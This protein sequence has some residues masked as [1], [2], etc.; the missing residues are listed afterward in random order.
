MK[1]LILAMVLFL[2]AS[3]LGFA[4]SVH[5][6]YYYLDLGISGQVTGLNDLGQMTGSYYRDNM[7]YGFRWD[8]GNGLKD[9]GTVIPGYGFSMGRAIN[10]LGQVAGLSTTGYITAIMWDQN[11]GMKDLNSLGVYSSSAY[12]IN[13]NGYVVGDL[14]IGIPIYYDY[15]AFLCTPSNGMVNLGTFGNKLARFTAINNKNQ[16]VGYAVDLMNNAK[17]FAWSSATGY[18]DLGKLTYR[19]YPNVI[20][21][22]GWVAGS[23]HNRPVLFNFNSK[24]T[25]ELGTETGSAT[26]INNKEQVV[27]IIEIEGKSSPFLWT[28]KS[29]MLRLTSLIKNLPPE[30]DI[31]YYPL[32]P[33]SINNNG[34]ILLAN[35]NY[36]DWLLTP[37]E[38]PYLSFD[39]I[40][41]PKTVGTPFSVTITARKVDGS[42]DTGLNG[43]VIVSCNARIDMIPAFLTN[44]QWQG[45]IKVL[46]AG[47]GIVL[48]ATSGSLKGSSQP[49]DVWAGSAVPV[50]NLDVKVQDWY[51]N[52]VP[53]AKVYLSLDKNGPAALQGVADVSGYCQFPG[54]QARSYWLWAESPEGVKSEPEWIFVNSDWTTAKVVDLHFLNSERTPVVLVPG[55]MG[56]TDKDQRHTPIPRLLQSNYELEGLQLHDPLRGSEYLGYNL[57]LSVGWRDLKDE[58]HSRGVPTVSCP[59]DWRVPIEDAVEKFLKPAIQRAQGGDSHK[60]VNVIAHS[61]GGLLVRHFIQTF[62]EDRLQ[63][64]PIANFSMVGTPN[65]GSSN[66]YFIWEGGDP[67]TLDKIKGMVPYYSLILL[68]LLYDMGK[69]LEYLPTTLINL[70]FSG[71]LLKSSLSDNARLTDFFHQHVRTIR[72]LLPTY[73]FLYSSGNL[74]DIN[75]SDGNAN[76]TLIRLNGDSRRFRMA[77]PSDPDLYKV[78]TRAY[79][80]TSEPTIGLLPVQKSPFSLYEDGKPQ[81]TPSLDRLGD[82]TVLNHSARLPQF[83]N[84][85]EP[86]L[87]S[88]EHMH[89]IR[90]YASWIAND[91]YPVPSVLSPLKAA[92]QSSSSI[93]SNFSLSFTGPVQPNISDSLGRQLGVNFTTGAVDRTIPD[94]DISIGSYNGSLTIDDPP[95][96]IYTLALKGVA[97]GSYRLSFAYMDKS[98]FV[99]K[100]YTGFIN[101]NVVTL[102]VS[103]DGAAA[104]KISVTAP[105]AAPTRLTAYASNGKTELSWTASPDPLTASYKVYARSSNSLYFAQIGSTGGTNFMT[106]DPWLDFNATTATAYAVAAVTSD[107]KESFFSN[108]VFNK[109]NLL[110]KTNPAPVLNLLLD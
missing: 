29:G 43:E 7:T 1:K 18:V 89:L 9:I 74:K 46:D 97:G 82:G 101:P 109:K 30:D 54:I 15:N 102:I 73:Q 65:E 62:P 106:S 44:G 52:P 5:A 87:I 10:N 32:T 24:E 85:G 8:P 93:K 72:E 49:F 48:R 88:G 55:F 25:I 56:S 64:L 98:N 36:H 4:Y 79:Y 39:S 35:Y 94:A 16:V 59:W 3:I 103:M 92:A 28:K 34:Q 105:V 37:I 27:G 22:N 96:G 66:A 40:Y 95:D 84:W 13:D 68:N 63:E 45:Q 41:S 104:D 6:S 108:L 81:G 78:K 80:S 14:I 100:D 99:V 90:D 33:I 11:T 69:W 2:T 61:M 76:E 47:G 17:N 71:D 77:P 91:L 107:G 51:L 75:N 83:E 12:G 19:S 86:I 23:L 26:A 70:Y 110:L 58:L 31:Y 60:K 21:D 50:G 67:L 38:A 53:K 57:N 42:V 20:N